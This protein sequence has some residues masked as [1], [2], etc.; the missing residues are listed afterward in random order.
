VRYRI[1]FRPAAE[2]SF[3][4]LPLSVRIRLQPQIEGLAAEPRPP[5]AKKLAGSRDRWRIRVGDYRVIYAIHS[6]V[7]RVLVLAVGHRREV[8]RTRS[9]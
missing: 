3:L 6:E 9:F 2:R 4:K 7:L 5:G 1:E 8:Y